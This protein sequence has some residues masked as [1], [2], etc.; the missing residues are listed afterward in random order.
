MKALGCFNDIMGDRLFPE[1]LDNHRDPIN[2]HVGFT[3]DWRN[4]QQ[5]LDDILCHCAEKAAAKDYKKFGL[6]YYAECWSGPSPIVHNR[7]GTSDRCVNSKYEM[8]P[9]NDDSICCG[10]DNNHFVYEL[11]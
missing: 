3:I 2:G 8:C 7:H 9:L 11:L 10:S 5:S 1:L 6:T 4:Y